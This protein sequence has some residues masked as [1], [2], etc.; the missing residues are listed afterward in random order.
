MS[1]ES[2]EK[3]TCDR[4][5]FSEIVT[6]TSREWRRVQIWMGYSPD[7][8]VRPTDVCPTCAASF[9]AWL[10]DAPAISIE[11]RLHKIGADT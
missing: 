6:D 5:G 10:T 8:Q 1:S 9:H 2:M 4:C 3:R 11:R 7:R